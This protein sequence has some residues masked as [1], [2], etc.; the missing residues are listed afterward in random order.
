MA[1]AQGLDFFF[2]RNGSL[3]AI[4]A[5]LGLKYLNEGAKISTASPSIISYAG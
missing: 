4:R 3:G 1:V 5:T 2:N